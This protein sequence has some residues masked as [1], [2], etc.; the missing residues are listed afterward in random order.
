MTRVSM[1]MT[2]HQGSRGNE[3]EDKKIRQRNEIH[4]RVGFASI[5]QYS[6]LRVQGSP[7]SFSRKEGNR[8]ITT[9]CSAY[10]CS[11]TPCSAALVAKRR[12]AKRKNN[13]K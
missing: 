7:P 6:I 9:N 5:F 13:E 11:T 10:L 12:E 3:M 8:R 4:M 2:T 1:P